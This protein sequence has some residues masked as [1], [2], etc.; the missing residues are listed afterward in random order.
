MLESVRHN[1]IC[2]FLMFFSAGRYVKQQVQG[3]FGAVLAGGAEGDAA[4]DAL[5]A[6]LHDVQV[7]AA[8]T[9]ECCAASCGAGCWLTCGVHPCVELLLEAHSGH[10]GHPSWQQEAAEAGHQEPELLDP[11]AD[12]RVNAFDLVGDIR[13]Q[14]RLL[15]Q[16]AAMPAHWCAAS[17]PS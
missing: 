5:A 2:S 15:A 3:G 6:Q 12:L 14:Q 7:R 11:V 1:L 16:R 17:K 10:S 9:S 4:A 13:R 8:K